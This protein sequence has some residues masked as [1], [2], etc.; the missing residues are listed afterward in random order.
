[1]KM[2]RRGITDVGVI[3]LAVAIII[4]GAL[5][6]MWGCPK[7]NVYQQMM[8]GKAKLAE[9]ESSRQIAVAEARAKMES[10]TLLAQAEVERAKGVA[11]S[12][13]IIGTSLKGND[14]YL[15]YLWIDGLGGTTNQVIYV[16][17]EAG[18]PIL[19][20]NRLEGGD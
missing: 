13:E 1:M 7:Y 6:S 5:V 9:A 15:R 10:A 19:E 2:S 14:E 8:S 17:T 18:L 12:N 3:L 11:E 16:P 20:A 4:A